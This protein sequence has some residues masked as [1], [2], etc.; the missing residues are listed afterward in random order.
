M[1]DDKFRLPGSS[2]EELTK[3]IKSYGQFNAPAGLEEVSKL[4]G[5][6]KTSIS[7]NA[8]FLVEL[9]ILESGQRKAL[10]SAGK[11]LAQALE[12]EM[13]EEIRTSWRHL[14]NENEFTTKLIS[15]IKI[16]NG[17]DENTLQSH[18]AYSAGQPKKPQY[19][20]G[21]KTIVDI[22]RASE[23]IK[24]KDGKFVIS[25]DEYVDENPPTK[26]E[27]QNFDQPVSVVGSGIHQI[28]AAS[29]TKRNSETEI[30]ININVSVECSVDELDKLG[31]KIRRIIEQVS[32]SEESDEH[33]ED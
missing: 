21:A 23:F 4:I 7:R 15:A 25:K 10:T 28:P 14:V 27:T 16:R 3:I 32:P 2:Y 8:G 11:S 31:N 9:S 12:H 33:S 6:D 29:I 20:T 1:A 17:M 26:D 22:L 13:P 5:M 30:K 24:E 19:M 18:I